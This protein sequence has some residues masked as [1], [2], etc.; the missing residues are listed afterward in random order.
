MSIKKLL[1]VLLICASTSVAAD[2]IAATKVYEI[3]LSSLRMP[4]SSNGMLTLRE[5]ND[6]ELITIR[7][8]Q[9]TRFML[10]EHNVDIRTFKKAMQSA[11]KSEIHAAAVVRD[12]ESNQVIAIFTALD[13]PKNRRHED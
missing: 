12:L 3:S 13:L 11:K 9:S 8:T 10:G 1:L 4:V 2:T 6:C 7:V 5:C